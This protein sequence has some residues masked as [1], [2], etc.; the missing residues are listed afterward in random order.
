MTCHNSKPVPQARTNPRRRALPAQATGSSRSLSPQTHPPPTKRFLPVRAHPS[1]SQV[2][3][4]RCQDW[5]RI[6]DSVGDKYELAHAPLASGCESQEPGTSSQ[7]S[8]ADQIGRFQLFLSA[9]SSLGWH[10]GGCCCCCCCGSLDQCALLVGKNGCQPAVGTSFATAMEL[11][12]SIGYVGSRW[13][14]TVSPSH[15]LSV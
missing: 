6:E 10:Y 3:T 9:A 12:H 5:Y 7:I 14:T 4:C 13:T 2:G 15:C 11:L 8:E 1:R